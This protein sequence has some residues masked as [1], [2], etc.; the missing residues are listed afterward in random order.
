MSCKTGISHLLICLISALLVILLTGCSSMAFFSLHSTQTIIQPAWEDTRS[1]YRY[2][3]G[4]IMVETNLY[5]QEIH[6]NGSEN[7]EL[8]L[9]RLNA[10]NEESPHKKASVALYLREYSFMKDYKP[11][12]T[13]SVKLVVEDEQG[14]PLGSYFYSTESTDSFF[15]SSYLYSR[16]EKGMARLF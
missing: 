10:E 5:D 4:V 3:P 15:S 8:L 12:K 13:L 2:I 6:R 1:S 16:I 14:N 9:D 7:L 11:L